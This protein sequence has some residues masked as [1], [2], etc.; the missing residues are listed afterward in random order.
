MS[1]G[2][3]VRSIIICCVLYCTVT[4][5]LTAAPVPVGTFFSVREMDVVKRGEIL[6]RVYLRYNAALNTK[7][8]PGP[9]NIPLTP[10]TAG[11]QG[12]EMIAE[13]KAHIPSS[14]GI[15]RVYNALLGWSKYEGVKYYS[16]TG[17]TLQPFILKA[18]TVLSP[19]SVQPVRDIRVGS[20]APLKIGYFRIRDNRLGW[21]TFRGELHYRD[22]VFIAKNYTMTP[23]TR[24]GMTVSRNGEYRMV[25]FLFPDGPEGYYLYSVH[26]LRIRSAAI[27]KSGL[28][29]SES[30]ANR[31]RACTV[32]TAKLLGMMWDGKIIAGR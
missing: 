14:P 32:H 9:F 8:T 25:M 2:K 3:D 30:F 24:Y 10:Y 19:Q 5:P 7:K 28:L 23:I 1:A 17:K 18:Y 21:L 31:I 13:E 6:T 11:I 4:C 22:N 12:W 29:N 15:L 16:V 26:A 27:L 20:P